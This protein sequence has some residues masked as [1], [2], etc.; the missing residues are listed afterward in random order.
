MKVQ[1][2]DFAGHGEAH[3]VV[4]GSGDFGNLGELDAA[5]LAVAVRA[6]TPYDRLFD[7]RRGRPCPKRVPL[8][9]VEGVFSSATLKVYVRAVRLEPEQ[10]YL[11]GAVRLGLNKTFAKPKLGR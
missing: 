11:Y 3:H 9:T 1:E 2:V 5:A 10:L 7:R 4:E 8:A 6:T